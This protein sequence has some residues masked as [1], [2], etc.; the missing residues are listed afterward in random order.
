[1]ANSYGIS[2]AQKF[3]QNGEY[4]QAIGAADKQAASEPEN[5][6]PHHDRARALA[7]LGRFEEAVTSYGRAIRLDETERVLSDWEVDDGLFSTLVAWGQS[8]GEPGKAAAAQVAIM[9]R[10]A[11][12]I[13]AGQHLEDAAQWILRFRGILKSTFVKPLN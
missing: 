2:F 10:Y 3:L 1:M 6:E 12:L 13:P 9:E 8:L 4:E 5:P 11:K 7:Q